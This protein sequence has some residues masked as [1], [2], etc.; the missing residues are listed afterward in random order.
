MFICPCFQLRNNYNND[1]KNNTIIYSHTRELHRL[2]LFSLCC[3]F[4]FNFLKAL[5]LF[6]GCPVPLLQLRMTLDSW[7]CSLY[8]TNARRGQESSLILYM[9][10]Y[11]GL[12]QNNCLHKHIPINNLI[13][14]SHWCQDICVYFCFTASSKM[15]L[16]LHSPP[17]DYK[18]LLETF[19]SV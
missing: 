6:L 4:C 14:S 13:F 18:I 19:S 9:F 16:T 10:S 2:F 12:L 17:F 3:L 7:S 1:G 5:S 11:L 15:N 8:L